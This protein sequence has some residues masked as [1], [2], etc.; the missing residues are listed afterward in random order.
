MSVLGQ[1]KLYA[2]G[3]QNQRGWA[4]RTPWK[5]ITTLVMLAATL[6]KRR[7]GIHPHAVC[8]GTTAKTTA[9]YTPTWCE[10]LFAIGQKL[11]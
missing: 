5:V 11:T 8:S 4:L 2:Y 3:L 10:A 7:D 6:G 1:L 9:Y